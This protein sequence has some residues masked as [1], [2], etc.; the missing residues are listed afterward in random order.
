MITVG[1]IRIDSLDGDAQVAMRALSDAMHLARSLEGRATASAKSDMSPVTVA[2]LA[3]QA[4]I[5]SRL[6]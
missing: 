4:V 3:I 5:A 1:S 2:D 6:F